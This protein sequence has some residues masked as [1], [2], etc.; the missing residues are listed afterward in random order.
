MPITQS[1]QQGSSGAVVIDKTDLAPA[2]PTSATATT[3]SAQIVAANANRKGLV[4][5]NVSNNRVSLGLSGNAAILN[6]G[7]TLYPGGI[8]VM[9]PF[10]FDV[11]AVM[12][13]ASAASSGIAI[14]EFS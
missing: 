11:G 5:T 2:A 7:I 12:A 1:S 14:Q 8:F 9:D 6:N 3:T 4:I 13:I 10:T